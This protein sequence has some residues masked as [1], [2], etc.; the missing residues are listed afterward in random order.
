MHFLIFYKGIGEGC[1]YT[2]GCN[3]AVEFAEAA[4][5]EQLE[6][7]LIADW[8]KYNDNIEQALEAYESI[9]MYAIDAS[10]DIDLDRLRQL[11]R[12]A[13]DN[14]TAKENERKERALYEKLKAKYGG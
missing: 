1:D 3:L 13:R 10:L 2:I 14:E 8:T 12:L 6:E 7:R 9:T 11:D 5:F 4:T